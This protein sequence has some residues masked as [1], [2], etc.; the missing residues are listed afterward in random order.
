MGEKKILAWVLAAADL[1]EPQITETMRRLR[2]EGVPVRLAAYL[3][4]RIRDQRKWYSGK[5]T[6]NRRAQIGWFCC[7]VVAQA[8]ALA[9]A[10]WSVSYAES[11][12]N[13]TGVLSSAAAAC[14]AWMQVKRQRELAQAYAL[15]AHE[16]GLIQEKARNVSTV[17]ELAAFVADSENAIS[18]EHTMWV[19]RRDI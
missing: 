11:I 17:A 9:A 14:I 4:G 5:A 1:A 6:L 8:A 19:A 3:S 10:I 7:V 16:L 18:R 13:L 15:A 2:S 12:P